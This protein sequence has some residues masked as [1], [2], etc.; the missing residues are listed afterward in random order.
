MKIINDSPI[1]V[2]LL[3][4]FGSV[5]LFSYFTNFATLYGLNTLNNN[6]N[7]IVETNVK[8]IKITQELL[9]YSTELAVNENAMLVASIQELEEIIYSEKVIKENIYNILSLI[10]SLNSEDANLRDID[11][12]FDSLREY[13][14]LL[15]RLSD[16]IRSGKSSEA[17]LLS[18]TEG[19]Q[20]AK[21]LTELAKKINERQF[22][23]LQ[24]TKATTTQTY[25]QQLSM[26]LWLMALT[27]ILTLYIIWAIGKL[28]VGSMKKLV[29][30]TELISAGDFDT[31]VEINTKDEIGQ[32]ADAITRMQTA[33]RAIRNK[34]D[35]L[36]WLKSGVARMNT[37]ILGQEDKM[38]LAST[39]LNE[40]SE[41]L[42][43]KIGAFYIA[44]NTESGIVLNLI[45]T[46]A[47]TQRKNLS[48]QFKLGENLVGQAALERKQI[49]LQ[50][51]PEDYIRVASGLGETVPTHIC[52]TPVLFE[53]NLKGVLE[54]GT[55][56]PLSELELNYLEQV[57]LPVALA[58]EITQAQDVM[59][60]QQEELQASN[61]ELDQQMRALEFAQKELN[62]QQVELETTNSE[63]QA[64]MQRVKDSGDELKAQQE[65]LEATNMELKDK[66]K[67]LERQKGDIEKARRS[68]EI[69]SEELALASKYKSE[70][71]ANMSHELRTPL[72]SL[73]L[74]ARTL[75][76]NKIGN[77][78]EDQI[79]TAGV[80]YESG[81]DLLN[82]INEILDLS[83]IEAG[84]MDLRLQP[85]ELSELMRSISLQ[86]EPLA[87][88]QNLAL[89]IKCEED[90]PNAIITDSQ[91]LGQVIKNLMG[92]A[93]K[94]TE[95]G[96]VSISFNHTSTDT[97]LSKSGLD[98]AS[99][100]TIA[101]KDTGIGIPL[102]KQKI[103]FEAFQQADS[104]DRRRFGGT[105]LGLSISRE[106]ANLLGGEIQLISM[107]GEGS[108]FSIYIPFVLA[109]LETSEAS[110]PSKTKVLSPIRSINTAEQIQTEPV[111]GLSLKQDCVDDRDVINDQDRV[112]LIIEDD[113]RFANILANES[114]ERGFKCLIS[115][116]GEEGV[117]LARKFR[118][119][120]IILD[121]ILPNMDGWDVLSDLKQNV[122]TRHI[123]VHIVSSED[124]S[125]NSLRIGAIGH[126]CKPVR[127]EDIDV[128]LERLE[129][130]S[131][132]AEKWVLLVEDDNVM[133][134]ETKRVIGNGNVKVHE[135]GTGADALAA[136]QERNFAL[137]IL[138]LGLPDMQ[139]LDLLKIISQQ[140]ITLPPV[141]VYTVRELT[142]D[143]EMALRSYA[144]SIIL[145]DV[146]SQE[147][148]I[149][150]IALF[151]HRVVNELPEDKKRVIRHL[152]ESDEHLKGRTILIVEDDMRTMFAMSKLLASHGI[153]P[154]KA[155]NGQK[156]LEILRANNNVDLILMDMMMP[157]MD[158]YEAMQRI[159]G[160]PMFV[161]LPIIALTAKAMKEDRKKCLEAGATDYL[162]KPVDMDRLLSLIRVWLCR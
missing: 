126:A 1:H 12:F 104:G 125:S 4:G 120:G 108:T 105:G 86:F 48:S 79:E 95:R 122:D 76:E 34:A 25:G 93:I 118:P 114:R 33:L 71:L 88:N 66:N 21:K 8:T 24:T 140:K 10:K 152:Y 128:I 58:F 113:P 100:L 2:K 29:V 16:L 65:E 75:V 45:G 161:N 46:F 69:Q 129:Q 99:T 162:S 40:I 145:K 14:W 17:I 144:D 6:F 31:S 5:L 82:L 67:L 127:K 142:M 124:A 116:T 91:R 115:L 13:D 155:E 134:K 153:N 87:K 119:D 103:I 20:K 26:S 77:L 156:A 47:Y 83:K 78:N 135:V 51:V 112:V 121:I 158:G 35:A 44:E 36:D 106:L 89:E 38:T 141:I 139:G 39:V 146:R 111:N 130:A 102:D 107:P 84:R 90:L 157:V 43:A 9:K 62:A 92:N 138:D 101:V 123:P 50:N 131:A 72:N 37:V 149:D 85:L 64:Q 137:I 133:C 49:L 55:L 60:T 73:L 97:D 41:Y 57:C 80:I 81:S 160:L 18:K 53:R 136:L 110:A 148:L 42:D 96:S 98:H 143:E 159:R 27:T 61:D 23:T 3:L 59:K 54:I 70:F 28:I 74:L 52:V 94:F 154:I 19:K 132:H 151:L 11:A 117:T 30:T 109:K 147:R 150:E 7:A 15:N 63:L 32:L 22:N 68:L 56:K